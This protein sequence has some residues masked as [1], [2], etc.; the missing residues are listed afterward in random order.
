MSASSG[1]RRREDE[2]LEFSPGS[3]HV[4][5]KKSQATPPNESQETQSRPTK[6]YVGG[7]KPRPIQPQTVWRLLCPGNPAIH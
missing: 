2:E 5:S 6:K 4:K 1:K 7:R 3:R